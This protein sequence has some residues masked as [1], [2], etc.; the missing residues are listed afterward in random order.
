M[1]TAR[2]PSTALC[3][4]AACALATALLL[5]T[6]HGQGVYR[7]VGPDGKVT[8]SDQPPPNA[9]NTAK[10]G[11]VGTGSDTTRANLPF[12][13][14]Q[15]VAKYPVTLYSSQGC[16]PCD[17]G[18]S[19]L[20][21]RGIPYIEKT[22][23]TNEDIAAFGR[24]SAENALPLLVIGGQQVKGFSATEWGQ[25]LDAAG[26]PKTSTLPPGYRQPAAQALVPLKTAA[27]APQPAPNPT[28]STPT[29]P[30]KPVRKPPAP[31]TNP[32]NPAGIKF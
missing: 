15:L 25:Y 6:A 19:V 27:E 8:F 7:I 23:N 20:A 9:Q 11:G 29:A 14:Q 17:S 2:R 5:P 4:A 13:L 18:R 26:Y 1:P 3:T 32:N 21:A 10:V 31:A 24:I 28:A 22:V 12:E 30:A 16:G